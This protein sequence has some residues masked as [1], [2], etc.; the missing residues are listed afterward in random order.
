MARQ[1]TVMTPENKSLV[2]SLKAQNKSDNSIAEMIGCNPQTVTNLRKKDRIRELIEQEGK[3]LILRGLIPARRTICRMAAKGNRD[4]ISDADKKLALD[5]SKHITGVASISG[6]SPSVVI[7]NLTQIN[8]AAEQTAE[9]RALGAFLAQQWGKET[10]I[11]A[12]EG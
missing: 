9:L 4:D 3:E 1:P 10:V 5:A 2:I 12:E 8:Q 7:N 6:N 11:D